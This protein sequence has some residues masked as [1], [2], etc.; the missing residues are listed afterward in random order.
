M[1]INH[2]RSLLLIGAVLGAC[3]IPAGEA[4]A[5]SEQDLRR[6]V[7]RLRERNRELER[8]LDA[9]RRQ[10]QSLENAIERLNN[11]LQQLREGRPDR[12]ERE[13][14]QEEVTIDESD[15]HA[16]PRAM[17]NAMKESYEE[18]FTDMEI[19]EAN[20]RQ[21]SLY[22]RSVERWRARINREM[23]GTI[24]WQARVIEAEDTRAGYL[25]RVVA[26]DPKTEVRLGEQ[27]T[28]ELPRRHARRYEQLVDRGQAERVRI[29]GVLTPD[30]QVNHDRRESGP[31]NVPPLIGPFAEFGFRIDVQ[32]VT[33]PDEA[34]TDRRDR[35]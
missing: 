8:E 23:R 32:A 19:G 9:A 11:R 14:D 30:V 26:V 24:E 16:S 17:F 3:L 20:D 13:A 33:A 18:T 1:K 15:P 35:R 4:V 25:L 7:E 27:F 10:I 5:Q 2:I 6:E 21:R 28:I 34:E 12:G 31:F 29:R 22:L